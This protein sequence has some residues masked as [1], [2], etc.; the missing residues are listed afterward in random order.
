[1]TESEK[2]ADGRNYR[3]EISL[4]DLG[5]SPSKEERGT[6][7][8][9]TKVFRKLNLFFSVHSINKACLGCLGLAKL[10]F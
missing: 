3:H 10:F 2:K 4:P 9:N 5:G 1:M 8:Q 6:K 7:Y